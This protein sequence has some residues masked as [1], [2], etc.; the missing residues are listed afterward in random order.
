MAGRSFNV[1]FLHMFSAFF[2]SLVSLLNLKWLQWYFCLYNTTNCSESVSQHFKGY[3]KQF[4]CFGWGEVIWAEI[5]LRTEDVFCNV[6]S[7]L[8]ELSLLPVAAQDTLLIQNPSL[9][10][11]QHWNSNHWDF[12]LILKRQ[13]KTSQCSETDKQRDFKQ[14]NPW[15]ES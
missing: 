9:G 13:V 8:I 4:F 10:W 6:A 1:S 7:E 14:T 11:Q 3:G 15:L 5:F 2:F 12:R